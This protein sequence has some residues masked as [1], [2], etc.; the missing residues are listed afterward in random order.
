MPKINFINENISIEVEE[1]TV[2][3]DAIR[4]ANLTI[5][6]PCNGMGFCGK[7]KVIARGNLSEPLDKEK[8]I[9]NEKRHERLS[10]MA[11]VLG[12]VEVELIEKNKVLKTIGK[13]FS[14]DVSI[15]SPVKILSLPEIDKSSSVPYVEYLGYKVNS[16]DLYN[17]IASMEEKHFKEIWG[18]VFQDNLLDISNYEKD[19]LGVAID[20]GTT[21]ISYYLVDLSNGDIVGSLSSL[22]PQTQYGGDVLSRITYCMED[23]KGAI[24]LQ[25]LIIDEINRTIKKIV[26]NIYNIDDIYHITISANTTMMHLLL[27]INPESLARAPYRSVF[28]SCEDIKAKDIAI[29]VNKEAILTI[30]P[31]ASSYVGGDIDR[32]LWHRVF[33]KNTEAVFIDIGTNGELA[34]LSNT[35]IISTSTAAGP[36]LEGMNIECGCR[37]EEGAIESFDIDEEFNIHYTTIGD[38]KAIGIC[39][40]GLIDIAGA[41]VKREILMKSGRWSKDLN[42]KLADKLVDKK[43]YITEDIYISQKDVRQIQLAKGA[44]AAGLIMMLEDIGLTIE[45]IPIVYIAGAF[46]YHINPK[47]IR[48]IG[49]IPK[50]F[51]GEIS[52]LGNTS[53]EGARLALINKR[54]YNRVNQIK[55]NMKVLELSLREGFQDIFVSQLNF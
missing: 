1:N 32:E 55:E 16:M 8:K 20:I 48:E 47:N 50:G 40:S 3:L 52:F 49:L 17:K 5:E 43:F 27:G 12:D 41:L 7:C 18:V 44:I 53:L 14:I 37:A 23:P 24:R 30:I 54:C 31:A 38:A 39:G 4:K 42:P 33:K 2:L 25:E 15:D 45:E 46:G 28:L 9:I 13:G 35:R 29:E 21:G 22:N 34:A 26:G 36:A 10:C 6:T 51:E 11:M 19:I